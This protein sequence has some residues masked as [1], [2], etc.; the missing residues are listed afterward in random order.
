D[1]AL[2]GLQ[3]E[4]PQSAGGAGDPLR[5]L[6]VADVARDPG[7]REPVTTPRADVPVEQVVTGVEGAR[8]HCGAPS[9]QVDVVVVERLAVDTV[10]GRGDPGGDLAPLV[11]RLHQR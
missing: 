8:G 5:E 10:P 4:A 7:Q 2:F 6:G 1:D 11:Y 3:P 9:D